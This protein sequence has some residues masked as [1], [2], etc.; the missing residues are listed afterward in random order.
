M[1]EEL[2]CEVE[3]E[4]QRPGKSSACKL[5]V[6]RRGRVREVELK[7]MAAGALLDAEPELWLARPVPAEPR[8][9]PAEKVDRRPH[10]NTAAQTNERGVAS[11]V[12]QQTTV[13]HPDRRRIESRP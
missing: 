2:S 3:T 4:V 12:G 7:Q 5:P 13:V 10:A 9:H 8:R 6:G 11:L 1:L